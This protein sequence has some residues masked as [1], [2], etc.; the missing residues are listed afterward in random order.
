[1]LILRST[2]WAAVLVIMAACQTRSAPA[3]AT[4]QVATAAQV[5][6]P[7]SPYRDRNAINSLVLAGAPV[8]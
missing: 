6:Y 3:P 5:G 4:T 8:A 1:M 2:I 7:Q